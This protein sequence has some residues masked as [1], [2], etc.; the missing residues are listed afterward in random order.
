MKLIQ[1]QWR[2]AHLRIHIQHG[3]TLIE[4]MIT[5]SILAILMSIAVPSF[6]EILLGSKLSSYANDFLAST[7]LARGEAIKRNSRVELCASSIGTSCEGNWEQGWIVLAMDGTVIQ[8]QQALSSGFRM[9]ATAGTNTI[10]FQATGVGVTPTTLIVC[11]ATPSVGT[12][13]REISVSATGRPLI[14]KRS[15]GSCP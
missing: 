15:M 6:K 11:Q 9:T 5:I 14:T 2:F 1:H 10:T 7:Y 4:L 13:E 3:F 8:R 12:H